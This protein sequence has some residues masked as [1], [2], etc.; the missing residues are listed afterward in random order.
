MKTIPP[1]KS[2]EA[3]VRLV[4]VLCKM[5]AEYGYESGRV[6][7]VSPREMAEFLNGR[8]SIQRIVA[9][10]KAHP[11]LVNYYSGYHKYCQGCLASRAAAGYYEA[12]IK[13]TVK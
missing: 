12:K 9:V 1:A 3:G 6:F 8:S 7:M 4:N 13:W 2:Q 5:A 11:E 10:A